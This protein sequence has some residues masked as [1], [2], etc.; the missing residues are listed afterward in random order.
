MKNRSLKIVKRRKLIEALRKCPQPG[1][2]SRLK[3]WPKWSNDVYFL[4]FQSND[5]RFRLCWTF[6]DYIENCSLFNFVSLYRMGL[7]FMIR[8]SRTNFGISRLPRPKLDSYRPPRPIFSFSRLCGPR[9]CVRDREQPARPKESIELF[10]DFWQ[11][12]TT[13]H[14]IVLLFF[15]FFLWAFQSLKIVLMLLSLEFRNTQT[16]NCAPIQCRNWPGYEI[17]VLR[18]LR[19]TIGL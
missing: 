11:V 15:F 8:R 1:W 13:E 16:Q 19:L 18:R 14:N 9:K 6:S 5:V 7:G 4:T 10:W 2:C 17:C 3:I 12:W